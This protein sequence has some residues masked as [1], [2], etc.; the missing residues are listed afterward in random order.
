LEWEIVGVIVVLVGLVTAIV[1]PV[2]KLNSS[3]TALT[4]TVKGFNEKLNK[5]EEKNSE[6]HGRL[7]AKNDEQD[8]RLADHDKRIHVL[9][10][11]EG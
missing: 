4:V 3:I 1:G 9:E 8:I 11:K 7:W 5:A 2:L 6:G 10:K